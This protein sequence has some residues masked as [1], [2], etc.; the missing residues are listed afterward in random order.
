MFCVAI[1]SRAATSMRLQLLASITADTVTASFANGF[2][3][4]SGRYPYKSASSRSA[5]YATLPIK[6]PRS[7][8]DSLNQSFMNNFL[9]TRKPWGGKLY[10]FIQR[11]PILIVVCF[12]LI[13]PGFNNARQKNCE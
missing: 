13:I 3:Y 10:G 11:L 2:L 7:R 4:S 8:E 12:V 1:G 6:S 5:K 9:I